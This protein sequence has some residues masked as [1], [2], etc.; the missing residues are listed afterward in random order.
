[1]PHLQAI[2]IGVGSELRGDAGFGAAVIEALCRQPGLAD[3][4]RLARCDGEPARMI[5]LW[6]GYGCALVVDAVRGGREAYGFLCRHDLPRDALLGS[7]GPWPGTPSGGGTGGSAHAAGLRAAVRLGHMLGR[8]PDRLILYA[9]HGRDFRPGAPL[10]RPV[11]AA[12]P[13]LA[14]RISRDVLGVLSECARQG[15]RPGAH[16]PSNPVRAL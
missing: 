3:R 1:M 16:R 10:S 8:L 14:G 7:T 12:V 15:E 13:Q 2:V 9:V 4:V 6:D 11:E 5:E